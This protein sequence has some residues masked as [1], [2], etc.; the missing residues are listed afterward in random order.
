MQALKI[1]KRTTQEPTITQQAK[2]L[3][4]LIFF[5]HKK[6]ISA[7]HKPS[8]LLTSHQYYQKLP[9][10]KNKLPYGN[11]LRRNIPMKF[12]DKHKQFAVKSYAQMMTR[13]EITA[14]FMQEN[15]A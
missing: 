11:L 5:N 6:P 12:S 15:V 1:N 9:S 7:T 14:T 8:H 2:K 3:P 13:A 10:C 4:K